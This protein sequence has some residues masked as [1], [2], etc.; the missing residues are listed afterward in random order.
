MFNLGFTMK[1]LNGR[2]TQ[3]VG[4]QPQAS[5]ELGT[6][7]TQLV[8][9]VFLFYLFWSKHSVCASGRHFWPQICDYVHVVATIMR[10]CPCCGPHN[11]MMS[12]LLSYYVMMFMLWSPW[13][14]DVH[15]EAPIMRWCP[16][17]CP[18][19]WWCSYCGPHDGMISMLWTP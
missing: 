13:W 18:I 2:Q 12:M 19:M 8:F 16:C 11:K 9:V 3:F 5:P 17:C 7:Q 15:V 14:D 10:W 6:A 4:R 1:S